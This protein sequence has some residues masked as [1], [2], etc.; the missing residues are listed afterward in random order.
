MKTKIVHNY[1][2]VNNTI[3]FDTES[4]KSH[5]EKLQLMITDRKECYIDI[6]LLGVTDRIANAIRRTLIMELDI[7]ALNF[8]PS[9]VSTTNNYSIRDELL[10][11]IVLIPLHQDVPDDA[12][13]K[14]S[15]I[16]STRSP[17]IVYSNSIEG[18]HNK[19]I[20][21]KI[22]L[23]KLPPGTYINIPEIRVI[24]DSYFK[25]NRVAYQL[26]G[27]IWYDNLDF[28]DVDFI[29]Q[30][31][32]RVTRRVRVTD[33]LSLFKE[34]TGNTVDQSFIYGKRILIIPGSDMYTNL[35]T[36]DKDRIK[37]ANYDYVFTNKKVFDPSIEYLK[38]YSSALSD[39]TDFRL[40]IFLKG[41]IEPNSVIPLVCDNIIM[42][43][44]K[45]ITSITAGTGHAIC[46]EIQI[47][48]LGGAYKNIFRLTII[49]ETHT[50]AEMISKQILV[51][52]P[53]IS[54]V[55]THM[56]HPSDK[57]IM[58]DIIHTEAKK[59]LLDVINSLIGIFQ[60]IK[61]DIK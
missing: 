20:P 39:S 1:K 33:L 4:F 44:Q 32:N 22:S 26:T 57:Q 31:C 17:M 11:R 9:T 40:R 21:K 52:I 2:I 55:K 29:N 34:Q 38:E 24:K 36:I 6:D 47:P 19:Y 50:I 54:L 23:V 35:S 18:E 15:V 53:S 60:N 28:K 13:F 46:S 3:N 61:S 8:D 37:N 27:Y 25:R 58:I 48:S 43:L 45:I 51:S 56:N 7:K 12:V 16:N 10:N 30:K 5:K 49:G 14:I 59:I 41:N 42:R